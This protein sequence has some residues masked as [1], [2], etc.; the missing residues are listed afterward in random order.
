MNTQEKIVHAAKSLFVDQGFA[1][2]QMKE[3]ATV[4]G[5]N[6]RT[7]YRYFPTKEDLLLYV[8]IE[9]MKELNGYLNSVADDVTGD[10]GFEKFR[11]YLTK[12]DIKRMSS[13]MFFIAQFDSRIINFL[14]N[15]KFS[16]E[17]KSI[18]D[19]KKYRLFDL[20]C[21]G[22]SDGSMRNDL[23]VLEIFM[24]LSHSFMAMYQRIIME[25]F[26]KDRSDSNAIDYEKLFIAMTLDG[27]KRVVEKDTIL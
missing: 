13:F 17:M 26:D 21:E 22:V 12:I 18:E 5:I 25:Q 10:N 7:L 24:Y 8:Y 9:A 16:Q 23:S 11:H 1:I 3:I 27:L 6:R 2:T 15:D 4:S 20:I 19:P 14:S